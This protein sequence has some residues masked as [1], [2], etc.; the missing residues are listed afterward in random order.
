MKD[1][2]EIKNDKVFVG[3]TVSRSWLFA[4]PHL[5]ANQNLRFFNKE[6]EICSFLLMKVKIFNHYPSNVCFQYHKMKVYLRGCLCSI[7]ISKL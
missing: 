2:I 7:K 6:I 5:V 3:T 4:S 1:E